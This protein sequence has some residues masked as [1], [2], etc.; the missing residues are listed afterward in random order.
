MHRLENLVIRALATGLII[1][2]FATIG[3]AA[4]DSCR[5]KLHQLCANV[6]HEHGQR[7]ACIDQNLSQLSPECQE[8]VRTWREQHQ[9]EGHHRHSQGTDTPSDSEG[10]RNED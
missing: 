3:A 4:E 10:S 5:Q 6:P 9:G 2:G 7:R 8:Q 1:G